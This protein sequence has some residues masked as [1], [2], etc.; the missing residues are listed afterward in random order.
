MAVWSLTWEFPYLER[1]SLYWDGTLASQNPSNSIVVLHLFQ[2]NSTKKIKE[3]H[4][5]SFDNGIQP[6]PVDSLNKG[7]VLWIAFPCQN[8]IHRGHRG[9]RPILSQYGW[10]VPYIHIHTSCIH[11]L[12]CNVFS[13]VSLRHQRVIYG[14]S[15]SGIASVAGKSHSTLDW[16]M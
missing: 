13:V 4:Y 2:F 3:A 9:L 6:S 10:I 7:P 5:W 8:F 11:I 12:T 1:R 16:P 15:Q 14:L